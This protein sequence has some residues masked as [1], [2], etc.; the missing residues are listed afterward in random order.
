MSTIDSPGPGMRFEDWMDAAN[1]FDAIERAQKR[2]GGKTVITFLGTD[3]QA[4]P[5]GPGP[6]T[7]GDEP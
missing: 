2:C 7:L 6:L 1:V 3:P 4:P 5:R